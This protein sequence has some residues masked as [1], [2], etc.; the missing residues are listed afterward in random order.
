M[1]DSV[2]T[3]RVL[4]GRGIRRRCPHCGKGQLLYRWFKI[5]DHCDVCGMRYLENQGDLL[6]PLM[7]ADRVV[8]L[9]PIVVVLYLLPH[10]AGA[11]WP[12]VV[13]GSLLAILIYT[14]PHRIGM[15]VAFDYF[16]RRKSRNLADEHRS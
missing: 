15:S 13:A 7:L 5:R 12:W 11:I 6:G 1:D 4:L 16:M 2:P 10:K 8:V 14:F 3:L 9:I